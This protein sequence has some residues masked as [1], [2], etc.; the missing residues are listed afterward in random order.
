MSKLNELDAWLEERLPRLLAEH[1]VPAA[2]IAVYAHGEVITRAAGVLNKNTG[3]EAT[4][5]SVFQIGSITK[6]WTATLVMQLVDEGTVDLDTP[7]RTYLPEFALADGKAAAEI[8]VRQ[9][10]CH[11]SGFEGDVFPD[12]GRGDDAVSKLMPLLADVPQLFAPG[13]MFSYNNAAYCVLGRLVEVLRDKPYDACLGEHLIKPLGLT[14]A[15]PSPYEAVM[16]RAAT[17]HLPSP[18][19]DGPVPAPV[20]AL[21]RSNAPA[22]SMLAMS[23]GDLITFARTHIDGGLGPDGTRVLSAE[24]TL[25][26]RQ[27]QVK[28]PKLGYMGPAWGLGWSLFDWPGGAVVGHDGGTIGQS[29]FLRVVPEH[30]V[31]V[32][33]LTNGGDTFPLFSGLV[34]RVLRELAGVEMPALPVPG[35]RSTPGAQAADAGASRFV[36]AYASSVFDT[37]ISQDPDGRLWAERIPKGALSSVAAEAPE[38]VELVAYDGDTLIATEPIQGL[39]LPYVFVGDDGEGH[40][41]FLHTGRADRRVK[42]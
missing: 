17:G 26:M 30:D 40:A 18:A 11:T 3:V 4:T 38:K 37:V 12:T 27:S 6:V 16:H 32:A 39:H 34:G 25:A 24:S 22:G 2:S 20:W 28:V 1:H 9:L 36:G 29:A 35:A 8:T 5:D 31:A 13:E 33:L 23:S 21:V 19:G 10:L 42:Q 15:A 41:L 7:V 14:H